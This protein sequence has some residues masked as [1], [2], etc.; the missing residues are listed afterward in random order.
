MNTKQAFKIGFI[1]EMSE[2]G[3]APDAMEAA[4]TKQ[5]FIGTAA[6]AAESADEWAG[7]AGQ[8]GSFLLKTMA[9]PALGIPFFLGMQMAKSKRMNPSDV[10]AI[11]DIELIKDYT[12]GAHT[13]DR[14]LAA[15]KRKERDEDV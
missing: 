5:S 14:S 2:R 10:K 8:L 12:E 7:H 3:V 13:L 4:L 6:A 11:S 1:R 15:R 9:V